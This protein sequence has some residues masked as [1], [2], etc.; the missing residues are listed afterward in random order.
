MGPK[1]ST[2]TVFKVYYTRMA[3]ADLGKG[4]CFGLS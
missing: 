1:I 2:H 4:H 3:A